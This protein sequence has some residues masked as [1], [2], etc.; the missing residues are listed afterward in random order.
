[1]LYALD[2]RSGHVNFRLSIGDVAHFASPAEASGRVYVAAQSHL[3]E[4]GAR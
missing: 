1:V 2:A 4:F 3:M